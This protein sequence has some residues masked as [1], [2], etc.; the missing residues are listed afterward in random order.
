[1]YHYDPVTALEELREEALLPNPVHVRDMVLR[2]SHSAQEALDLNR[3][4]Q[5][6]Q[7]AYAALSRQGEELLEALVRAPKRD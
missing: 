5:A 6:Y 4:F 1:M 2:T 3:R 7:A